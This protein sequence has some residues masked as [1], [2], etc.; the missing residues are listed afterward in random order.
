MREF[1]GD[2]KQI[3]ASVGVSKGA[4]AET[5]GR[6]QLTLEELAAGILSKKEP[7][8]VR[9][10]KNATSAILRMY[11][12]RFFCVYVFCVRERKGPSTKGKAW[13]NVHGKTCA[14]NLQSNL[15]HLDFLQLQETGGRQQGLDVV[16]LHRDFGSVTEV[17]EELHRR[18]VDVAYRHFRLPRLCQLA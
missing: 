8:E 9:N 4:N 6:V 12:R 16:L 5:I 1:V 2:S 15:P 7:A 10:R 18:L 11:F 17:Y 14:T 13:K 3:S